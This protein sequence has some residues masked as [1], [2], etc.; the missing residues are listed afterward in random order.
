MEGD[1]P[2]GEQLR[3]WR[4]LR[5]LSQLDLALSADTSARHISFVETGR[6]VPSREMVLRLAEFLDV[7]LR[8]RNRLLVAAGHAPRY[9]RREWNDPALASAREAVWRVLRAHEPFPALAVDS[10]WNLLRANESVRVFFDG[11]DPAL[12]A[13]PVNMMRIGLHPRG[14]AARLRNLDQVRGVLL[15]RLARQ[16]RATGDRELAGLHEELLS[17]GVPVAAGDEAGEI[18]LPIRLTHGGVE[19]CLFSTLTVFGTAFDITLAEIAVEAYFPADA[20]T[21]TYLR[22]LSGR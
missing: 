2:V 10:R 5:R 14:F 21:E 17:Y 6:T 18:A 9:R 22:E 11:V 15:P 1:R 4:R 8:E 13:E 19:L 7:P 16:V 20:R 3:E 12:L